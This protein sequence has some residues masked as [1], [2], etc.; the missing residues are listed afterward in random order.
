V[1]KKAWI[2]FAAICVVLLGGLIFISSKDKI[3]VSGVDANKTQKA[4]TQSGDIADHVYGKADS[5]VVLIE[6]GDYQCPG[7]GSAYPNV[8]AVTEKYKG[9][10]AFIFRNFPI[11]SLHPNAR[12]AAAVAEAAG[13]QGKFWEMHNK[14]YETQSSWETLNSSERTDFFVSYAKEMGLNAETFKTDLASAKVNQ[15]IS[16]DQAI[17]KKINV[18]ATPTF[19]L[20]GKGLDQS[21]WSDQDKLDATIVAEMKNNGISVPET[22]A[23][24]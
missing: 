22:P 13:L 19:Y 14:L 24:Q 9:Q 6:Y 8:K 1:S 2:I 5:K 20:N 12:V 7:C 11:T 10:V 21:S 23:A 15:K 17:G 18:N 3:D 16:Y 4:N